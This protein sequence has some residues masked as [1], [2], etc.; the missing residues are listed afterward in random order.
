MIG[1]A[2]WKLSYKWLELA[3]QNKVSSR[4]RLPFNHNTL[5]WF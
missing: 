1:N 4:W 3:L 5:Q 2:S